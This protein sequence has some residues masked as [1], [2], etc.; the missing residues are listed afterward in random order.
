MGLAKSYNYYSL[1]KQ[2]LLK[3][4]YSSS[5][6]FGYNCWEEIR[7]CFDDLEE[8]K[9]AFCLKLLYQTSITMTQSLIKSSKREE[10][11]IYLD[12]IQSNFRDIS[13]HSEYSDATKKISIFYKKKIEQ[14]YT[15]LSN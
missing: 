13:N 8:T 12:K 9:Q 3:Q 2:N 15:R 5:F 1:S 6:W 11:F 7:E 4:D 10:A 14:E